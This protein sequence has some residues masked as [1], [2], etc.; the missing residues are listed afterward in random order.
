MTVM[1]P[2]LRLRTLWVFGGV[3]IALVIAYYCLTPGDNLPTVGV[4]DK[5]QHATAFLVLTLWLAGIISRR[6]HMALGVALVA[7][8]G[9]LELGQGWLAWGRSADWL[10]L[11]ADAVGVVIGLLLALTPLGRWA[12][13]LESLQRRPA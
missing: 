4:S 3:C 6:W 11:L 8:G 9:L 12:R 7:Y 2:E 5:I 1:L 13:W 10:D